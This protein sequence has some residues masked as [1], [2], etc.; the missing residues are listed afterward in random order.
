MRAKMGERGRRCE[1]IR[2]APHGFA[3]ALVPRDDELRRGARAA[4]G[5][6]I[7]TEGGDNGTSFQVPHFQ[8][9]RERI[10]TGNAARLQPFP[11]A[12]AGSD[13]RLDCSEASGQLN[14]VQPAGFSEAHAD[15]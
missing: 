5:G 8:R 9:P 13:L 14:R 12:K 7:A 3:T 15:V 6:G 11:E 4:T 2:Q 10:A 1:R